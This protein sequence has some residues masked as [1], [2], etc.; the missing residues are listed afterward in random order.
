MSQHPPAQLVPHKAGGSGATSPSGSQALPPLATR[1]FEGLAAV[2]GPIVVLQGVTGVAYGEAAEV[3]L[4]DGSVR[5]GRVLE[6]RPKDGRIVVDGIAIMKR[7]V[8]QTQKM[9]QAGIVEMPGPIHASNA[10]LVC[11][12]CDAPTRVGHR[13]HE[14]GHKVRVCKKCGKDIDE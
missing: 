3:L 11:P 5:R 14:N 9:R 1:V 10:M 6:V 7:A 13:T 8:R 4:P 12:N 2:R